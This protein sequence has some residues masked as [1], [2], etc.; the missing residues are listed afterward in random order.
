VK[1]K[2]AIITG[3]AGFIG[4]HIADRLLGN[5]WTVVGID[6]LSRRGATL[7]LEY[8]RGRHGNGIE[9]RHG[10]IR[11]QGRVDELFRSTGAIDAVIHEAAQVAVTSSV[12]N[13]RADMEINIVGTFNL[14]EATRLHAPG[15]SFLYASTNKVYGD[16]GDSAVVELPSRY[17]YRDGRIGI[18]ETQPLSFHSPY[19]CSKGAAD[20][21]VSDY[22]RIY[23]LRTVVFRQSCIY[24]DRQYGVEDQG[25][26]SW[27]CI[28]HELGCPIQVYGDG[29]QVRDLLHVQDLATLCVKAI[30]V[31]DVLNGT[32]F[33]VGGG[34]ASTLSILELFKIMAEETGKSPAFDFGPWRP[35]DQKIFVSDNQK[36][37]AAFGWKANIGPREG[38]AQL[39][40]WVRENRDS[41]LA[42]RSFG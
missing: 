12:Q 31:P 9:F 20:Q 14:L 1:G 25:W 4:S 16:L 6:N 13:P 30:A 41:L 19:G 40:Q 36:V 37:E 42:S 39:I 38:V 28:A 21:Y 18:A 15:A 33:N 5:G 35:G 24:G 2:K 22:G 7:N 27:F 32:V 34:S 17:A 8:L 11:D 26:V 10:D 29:K 3:V 23:G